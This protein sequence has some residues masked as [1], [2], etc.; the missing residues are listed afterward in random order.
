MGAVC[1][2]GPLDGLGVPATP[3]AFSWFDCHGRAFKQPGA[4][5]YLYQRSQSDWHYVGHRAHLCR[6]CKAIIFVPTTEACPMCAWVEN[7]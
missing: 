6:N 4:A 5:R 7:I 3:G 2:G 1:L